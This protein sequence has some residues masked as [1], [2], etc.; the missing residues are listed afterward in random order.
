VYEVLADLLPS[1]EILHQRLLN[2]QLE[3]QADKQERDLAD[4]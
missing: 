3:T 2:S 1:Q 4:R